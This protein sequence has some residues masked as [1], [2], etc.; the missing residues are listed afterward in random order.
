VFFHAIVD[1]FINAFDGLSEFVNV[2]VCFWVRYLPKFCFQ[3]LPEIVPF[4]FLITRSW[5]ESLRGRCDVDYADDGE[6]VGFDGLPGQLGVTCDEMFQ[7][8]SAAE[9]IVGTCEVLGGLCLKGGDVLWESHL[10]VI[11]PEKVYQRL[12]GS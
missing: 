7:E 4:S 2:V 8:P 3:R 10:H 1:S 11:T 6:M 5:C 9:D 12:S